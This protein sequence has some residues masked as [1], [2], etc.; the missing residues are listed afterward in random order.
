LIIRIQTAIERLEDKWKY[1]LQ[2]V[3]RQRIR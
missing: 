1:G 3:L 2:S